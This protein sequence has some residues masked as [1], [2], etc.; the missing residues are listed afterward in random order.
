MAYGVPVIAADYK[1]GP[2]EILAPKDIFADEI[3]YD[4]AGE[5]GVL[6]KSP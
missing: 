3:S 2:R 6:I 4:N 5:Y 1:S